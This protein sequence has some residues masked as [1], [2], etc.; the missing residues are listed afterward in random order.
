[1]CIR[2]RCIEG[3]TTTGSQTRVWRINT[4]DG[5]FLADQWYHVQVAWDISSVTN[6]PVC[7]I[8]GVAQT[9]ALIDDT[10]TGSFVNDA[11]NTLRLGNRLAGDRTLI[12]D[13]LLFRFHT[14]KLSAA[15]LTSNYLHDVRYLRDNYANVVFDF[16]TD[17]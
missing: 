8:N 9:P 12:W 15:D 13:L 7:Y 14:A 3:E 17:S 11:G 1:M 5:S 6:T 2:D 10:G 16:S 4:T